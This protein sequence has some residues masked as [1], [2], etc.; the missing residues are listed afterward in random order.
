MD[1]PQSVR[2]ERDVVMIMYGDKAKVE[3][4]IKE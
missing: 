1:G 2:D 4:L 3:R